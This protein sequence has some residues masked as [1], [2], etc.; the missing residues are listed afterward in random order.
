M[1]GGCRVREKGPLICDDCDINI[2]GPSLLDLSTGTGRDA[3]IKL[4]GNGI[5]HRRHDQLALVDPLLADWLRRR[6]AI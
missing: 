5:L 6:F 1:C 2:H 3:A 4:V